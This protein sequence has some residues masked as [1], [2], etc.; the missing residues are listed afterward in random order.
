MALSSNNRRGSTM[1]DEP[2]SAQ[3]TEPGE[4]ARNHYAAQESPRLTAPSVKA[5]PERLVS[6]RQRIDP[7]QPTDP[8]ESS[9]CR[10]HR[11]G[12][13]PKRKQYKVHNG[14]ETFHRSG[15]P[16]RKEA[17]AGKGEGNECQQ[18]G[19]SKPFRDS[20][21]QAE[22]WCNQHQQQALS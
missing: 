8:S 12:K 14:V 7:H 9:R 3:Q 21:S 18:T 4:R 1:G 13:Q 5:I 20:K 15:Q 2:G 11:P 6:V 19:C 16:R 22:D 10:E 17:E